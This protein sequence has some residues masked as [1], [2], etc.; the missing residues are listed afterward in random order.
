M[1]NTEVIDN[2]SATKV[3][4]K[5][6]TDNIKKKGQELTEYIREVKDLLRESLEKSTTNL[7]PWFFNNMPNTYYHTTPRIE[8]IKHLS[9]IITSNIFETK[10]TIQIWSKDRTQVTLIGPTNKESNKLNQ[11]LNSIDATRTTLGYSYSSTDNKI[12]I[13]TFF[14]RKL[15][16]A[17]LN[18]HFIQKKTQAASLLF[19][20]G[21][22]PNAIKFT[23]YLNNLDHCFLK[24]ASPQQLLLTYKML[25]H[26]LTHEG[27]HTYINRLEEPNTLTI[28]IGIK[29]L[30]FKEIL[31]KTIPLIIRYHFDIK[32][33]FISEFNEGYTDIINIFHIKLKY[34]NSKEPLA[35][36]NEKLIKALK[37]ISWCD[38]DQ[39]LNF[40]KKPFLFSLNAA[41]LFRSLAIWIRITLGKENLYYYSEHNIYSTFN[42]NPKITQQILQ[43]FRLKFNLQEKNKQLIDKYEKTK[44]DTIKEINQIMNKVQ[45]RI[46]KTSIHFI[47]CC[48][49]T[50]YFLHS[51]TGL[52]FRLN[53]DILDNK[54]Y[55]KKPFTIIFIVGRDYRFFHIRWRDIARGGLRVIIPK[56][57]TEYEN[58]IDGLLDEVYGLS[59]AQQLKNKDIPEG[60]AKGAIVIK[61]GGDKTRV[62]KAAINA[63]LDLIVPDDE[64]HEENNKQISYYSNKD[65]IYLGP[66]ENI[67]NDLICWI[68]EQAHKRKYPYAN[69]FMSSKPNFGINHK[70]YGVTSQ[71]LHIHVK[72]LLE[73]LNI[74]PQQNNFTVKMTGG[75]DGDVA[76]NELKLLYKSYPNTCKILA[77]SDGSG[78]A[79]DPNGLCWKEILNLIEKNSPIAMF[80]PKYLSKSKNAF[81]ID[82]STRKNIKIR[83]ELHNKVKADIF[84]PAGGRPYTVN[85]S[86]VSDFL[87]YS[88]IPTS[89]IIVEG[90]NIFFTESARNRLQELG[91][92]M[93]KD[94]SANKTGVICS[95]YETIASIIL[96]QNEFLQIKKEYIQQVIA[97]LIQKAEIE[98]NLLLREFS[99]YNNKYSLTQISMQLSITINDLTD[100]IYKKIVN[101]SSKYFEQEIIKYLIFNHCPNILVKN[102]SSRILTKLPKKYLKALVA[103]SCASFIIYKEGLNWIYTFHEKQRYDVVIEYIRNDILSQKII[104]SLEKINL[105]EKEKIQFILSNSGAK[106]LTQKNLLTL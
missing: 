49:R 43:I 7:T 81:V 89:K 66:D 103:S 74:N 90:A 52:A 19:N 93:I 83:N 59:Y 24:Y 35:I 5:K 30:R 9:A 40:T 67:T 56:A 2:H 12:F 17:Q 57:T 77:I 15:V 28:T 39:Y 54:Y 85:D 69:A 34:T 99:K 97:I 23:Y 76:S 88:G 14:C 104:S 87:D 82:V 25:S 100:L 64:T 21:R 106:D 41:S 44:T 75:C 16:K 38:S 11:L 60:G 92:W 37:T 4:K 20:K 31:E 78:A 26:M 45:R 29:A 36:S 55:T 102:Y 73:H 42:Q 18:N 3:Q 91:V 13:T 63:L 84:I 8:K 70:E 1:K 94:S 48:L 79:H 80:D 96:S 86:N 33:Y 6:S 32:D 46:L 58:V 10:Q 47:D 98:S 95:S 53:P 65:T 101:K 51:K 68:Q 61:P 27:S 50:N 71:G 105:N 72:A 22:Y 62:V